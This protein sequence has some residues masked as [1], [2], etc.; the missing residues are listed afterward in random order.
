MGVNKEAT[1]YFRL[2]DVLQYTFG[3]ME[4]RPSYKYWLL[5]LGLPIHLIVFLFYLLKRKDDTYTS[6]YEE[7]RAS[8]TASGYKEA[9]MLDFKEQLLR[10]HSFFNKEVNE[11]E[12]DREVEKL[13]EEQFRKTLTKKTNQ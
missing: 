5:I 11:Q 10:K 6:I 2:L 13:A 12:I 4:R 7:V 9:S 3:K 8:L 1:P